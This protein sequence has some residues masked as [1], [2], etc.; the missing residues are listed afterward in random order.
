MMFVALA[1][2]IAASVLCA[3]SSGILMLTAARV[4]QGSAA[5]G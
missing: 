5:A 1:V 4:L 3:V 2:F